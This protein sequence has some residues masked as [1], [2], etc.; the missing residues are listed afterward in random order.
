MQWLE[1]L[2]IIFL[3]LKFQNL[4]NLINLFNKKNYENISLSV[5]YEL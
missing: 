5:S 2:N 1:T 4:W 3:L